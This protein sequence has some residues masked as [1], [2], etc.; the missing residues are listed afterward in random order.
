M[1][2]ISRRC[3]SS[4][5]SVSGEP[6][7]MHSDYTNARLGGADYARQQKRIKKNKSCRFFKRRKTFIKKAHELY[8]DCEV[9]IFICVRSR[10][11]NQMWQ[12][13]NDFI[14]PLQAEIVRF[15]RKD[16]FDCS[17]TNTITRTRYIPCLSSLLRQATLA[18]TIRPVKVRY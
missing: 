17:K 4:E 8:K 3:N 10:R 12:Y 16:Q 6:A 11:N 2:T 15:E 13:S 1:L 7:R 5:P 18:S 9:D 14:P